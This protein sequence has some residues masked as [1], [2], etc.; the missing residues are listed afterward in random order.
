MTNKRLSGDIY[1][2]DTESEDEKNTAF[3]FPAKTVNIKPGFDYEVTK[4]DDDTRKSVRLSPNEIN[5][6]PHES[7]AARIKVEEEK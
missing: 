6:I 3:G 1:S 4:V 7:L 2:M 5:K